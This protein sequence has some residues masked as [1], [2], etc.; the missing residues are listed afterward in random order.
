M[1]ESGDGR[2]PLSIALELSARR[3]PPAPAAGSS[4]RLLLEHGADV[5]QRW[6][7]LTPQETPLE[8]ACTIEKGITPLM[9]AARLGSTE[10]V[11][12]LLDYK[13]DRSLTDWAGRSAL[14]YA[15]WR[16]VWDLLKATPD[17]CDSFL[18]PKT[19]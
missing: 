12:L 14:H 10:S 3:S 8:P 17:D 11:T 2:T 9:W 7:E 15:K 13:A 6:C 4:V 19:R 16:N 1:N 5:N 18:C